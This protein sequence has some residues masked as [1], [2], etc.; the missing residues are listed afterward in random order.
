MLLYHGTSGSNSDSIVNSGFK[1][2]EE[3]RNDHWL[4]NG[5]Y[6]FREDHTQALTWAISRFKFERAVTEFHVIEALLEVAP[7]NFL[8]LDSRDGMD[9]YVSW[10]EQVFADLKSSGMELEFSS[11]EMARCFIIDSMP[12]QYT[13]IQR[14]FPGKS[15]KFDDNP[16]LNMSGIRIH[17]VQVCVRAE[18]AI[19]G[20]I[21]VV[22]REPR[23]RKQFKRRNTSMSLMSNKR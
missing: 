10:G 15:K 8:N 3:G 4:G 16:V 6:F 1:I 7:E 17:G 14:T 22:H 9:T 18:E 5:I 13:V 11:A 2:P 21:S 23:R 12:A 19:N 20:A